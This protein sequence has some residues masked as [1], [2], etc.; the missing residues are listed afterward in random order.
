MQFWKPSVLTK[1]LRGRP[2]STNSWD[3][4]DGS[5]RSLISSIELLD[6]EKDDGIRQWGGATEHS[7]RGRT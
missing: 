3:R 6:Y 1:W 2:F 7:G 4:R 5:G